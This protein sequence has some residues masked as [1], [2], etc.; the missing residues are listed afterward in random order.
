MINFLRKLRHSLI[1]ENKTGRYFRYAIG[2]ILLVV[3]GILIA[4]QINNW[5]DKG[6]RLQKENYYLKNIKIN[7]KDSEDEITRVIKDTDSIINSTGTLLTLLGNK[8]YHKLFNLSICL[9]KHCMPFSVSFIC[10]IT[11]PLTLKYF[12]ALNCSKL[13]P[14]AL[15][16]SKTSQ[17]KV[18]PYLLVIVML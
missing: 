8:E 4:L 9:F 16:M 6:R 11:S 1:K 18:S 2:E 13:K 14:M 10:L 17:D 3:I 12:K 7:I 5:N 15:A